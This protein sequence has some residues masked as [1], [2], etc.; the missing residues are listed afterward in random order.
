[1]KLLLSVLFFSFCFSQTIVAQSKSQTV[2]N[3]VSTKINKHIVVNNWGRKDRVVGI[4]MNRFISSVDFKHKFQHTGSKLF[5]SIQHSH[6]LE[7]KEKDI[8]PFSVSSRMF[9][10]K[11]SFLNTK[12]GER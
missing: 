2:L 12:E 5:F 11:R 3:S 4:Y 7:R 10:H 8:K 9:N 1:M 6:V